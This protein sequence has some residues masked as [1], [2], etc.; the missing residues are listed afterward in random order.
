MGAVQIRGCQA[1]I[2]LLVDSLCIV[3]ASPQSLA[4]AGVSSHKL[5]RQS[6]A[7]G[8]SFVGLSVTHAFVHCAGR[9]G[10]RNCRRFTSTD[11]QSF[12]ADMLRRMLGIEVVPPA[13][14]YL[15][16]YGAC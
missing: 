4:G 8:S 9:L 7:V 13:A 10:G 16:R 11:F 2:V 15:F 12:G 6:G 1:R 14:L 5:F 3:T